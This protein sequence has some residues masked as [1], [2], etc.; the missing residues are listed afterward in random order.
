MQ[1]PCDGGYRDVHHTLYAAVELLL[2][3]ETNP[4][5]FTQSSGYGKLAWA[6]A[7]VG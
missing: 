4:L 3:S 2:L 7:M 5:I 6:R 1:A